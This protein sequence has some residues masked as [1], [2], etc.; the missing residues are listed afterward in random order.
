MFVLVA[1]DFQ[2]LFWQEENPPNGATFQAD[3]SVKVWI[4]GAT[5]SGFGGS[6]GC[7]MHVGMDLLL[8]LL[9]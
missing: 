6:V 5:K 2:V 3:D 7:M 1:I 8:L 9:L 4:Q